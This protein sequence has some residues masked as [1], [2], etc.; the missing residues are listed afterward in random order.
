M[1]V[2]PNHEARNY[3]GLFYWFWDAGTNFKTEENSHDAV[4]RNFAF[5]KRPIG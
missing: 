1:R 2:A 5:G 3:A 4:H